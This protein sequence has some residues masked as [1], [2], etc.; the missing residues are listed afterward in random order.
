MGSVWFVCAIGMCALKQATIHFLWDVSAINCMVHDC[1]RGVGSNFEVER[2]LGERG[3][4][5]ELVI[6]NFQ[7]C[8]INTNSVAISRFLAI[9]THLLTT[10][11][12]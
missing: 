9:S 11:Y 8:S 2:P 7:R 5:W 10:I 1:G 4:E 3:N 12:T 6:L